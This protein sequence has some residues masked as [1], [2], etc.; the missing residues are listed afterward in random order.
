MTTYII[1]RPYASPN[2]KT[3]FNKDFVII[4]RSD[5]NDYTCH[6][7]NP[8]QTTWKVSKAIP[9]KYSN[10]YKTVF[11]TD[12]AAVIDPSECIH[13]DILLSFT[14]KEEAYLAKAYL[15]EQMRKEYKAE[16]EAILARMERNVPDLSSIIDDLHDQ[17]PEYF[18]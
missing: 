6:T 1:S 11:P 8:K 18:L 4:E 15:I 12:I 3:S 14:S 10:K 9:A 7:F 5:T 17:Y 16:V 13:K 2:L